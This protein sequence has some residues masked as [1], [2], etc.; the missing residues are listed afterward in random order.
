L[1]R[2]KSL[3]AHLPSHPLEPAEVKAD[4]KPITRPEPDMG[5]PPEVFD[6]QLLAGGK[7]A[8]AEL[9]KAFLDGVRERH[10]LGEWLVPEIGSSR[11]YMSLIG[12]LHPK[13]DSY[14][15]ERK[16]K[17]FNDLA[18]AH[19]KLIAEQAKWRNKM[20]GIPNYPTSSRMMEPQEQKFLSQAMHLIQEDVEKKPFHIHGESGA[21]GDLSGRIRQFNHNPKDTV[22][23][24]I[25]P[26]DKY[27]MHSH[28]PFSEPFS[29]SASE[30]DHKGAAEEY[31]DF[32]NKMSN[33]LTNGKDV[34]EIPSDSMQLIK[35]N[36]DPKM[37]ETLGKFPE[38]FRVPDPQ[39]PPYPFQNHEAPAAFKENWEP[40]AGWKP[41][42]DYPRG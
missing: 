42:E 9:K 38:A 33:Y 19:P 37:E 3:P 32:N 18:G 14:S 16:T 28:P 11:H 23:L 5:R 26:G 36:P 12:S 21:V 29:S 41:P 40:P 1:K 6:F 39:Q 35:L 30:T 31:L 22:S 2:S 20:Y 13:F 8:G 7:R 15:L 17:A 25:L 24:T 4:R 27:T 34:L 10:P